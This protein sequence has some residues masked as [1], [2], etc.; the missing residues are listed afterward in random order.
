MRKKKALNMYMYGYMGERKGGEGMMC[1]HR[2]R[3]VSSRGAL[4]SE[5]VSFFVTWFG[6]TSRSSSAP[7][8]ASSFSPD[9]ACFFLNSLR[10]TRE[11]PDPSGTAS[12]SSSSSSPSSA[13]SSSETSSSSSSSSSSTAERLQGDKKITCGTE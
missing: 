7:E 9:V 6:L 3:R 2:S 8:P 11:G 10:S 5:M 12:S 13:S 4:K 1:T